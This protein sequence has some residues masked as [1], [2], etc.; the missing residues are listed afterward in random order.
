MKKGHIQWDLQASNR[1][2]EEAEEPQTDGRACARALV[3]KK[4]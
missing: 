3:Q 2:T 1:Q 4:P